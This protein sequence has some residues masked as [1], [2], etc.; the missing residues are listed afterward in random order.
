[1]D[2]ED[3][4]STFSSQLLKAKFV[5]TGRVLNDLLKCVLQEIS[6]TSEALPLLF[7]RLSTGDL[8]CN[9]NALLL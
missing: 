1:M 5:K 4:K 7:M 8:R 9:L 3:S 6:I 2:S